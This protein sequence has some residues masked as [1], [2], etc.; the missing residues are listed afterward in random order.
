MTDRIILRG[1]VF[2]AA[3][4]VFPIESQLGQDFSVSLE[5]ELS[6][7]EAGRSDR[8]EDTVDYLEVRSL[9]REVM[10]GPR[11][12]LL[13]TLAESIAA[14][15]LSEFAQIA[16]VTVEVTKPRPPVDFPLSVIS[17]QIRRDRAVVSA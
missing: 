2:F 7:A 8:L 9:V 13:E 17:I 14:K 5:L 10:E 15:I 6:L 12:K 3:H 4:G 11:R 16:A 1:L